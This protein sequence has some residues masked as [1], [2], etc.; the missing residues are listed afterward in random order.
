VR[1][2]PLAAI[3]SVALGIGRFA[4]LT[5]MLD[6]ALCQV[7]EVVQTEAG[8]VYLLDEERGE[9]SLVVHRGLSEL[10]SRDF[11]H[12]GLGEGLSGR[13]VVTGEPI[14][15]RNL[16]DDPRLT[17]MAARIEGFQAFASVP[18]RSNF[19]TYGTLNVHTRED[20]AFSEED[21]QLLTSMASQIGLAVANTRLYLDLRASERRF[22][23][24]VENA[25]DLIYLTDGRG[26]IV[27]ANAALQ[28]LLGRDP[29]A[30]DREPLTVLSLT[31]PDDREEMTRRLHDMLDG[32][33]LRAM[34]VRFLHAD[35][36]TGRWFSQTNVPLRDET[37]ALT[38]MQCLAHDITA[39]REMQSQVAQAERLADLGRMAAGIAHEIRNPLGAMVNSIEVLRRQGTTLDQ[40]LL[41]ILAAEVERL[42]TIVSE[43]LLFAR[44]PT[45]HAVPCDVGELVHTTAA[46]FRRGGGLGAGTTLEVICPDG[47][48]VVTADPNQLRQVLWNLLANASEAMGGGGRIDLAATLADD[49]RAVSVAVADQGPGVDRDAAVFEP[50]FTT[51]AQGTGLGLSIVARI[52]AEH[53]GRVEV[54]PRSGGG[55]VFTVTLPVSGEAAGAVA[56]GEPA[57]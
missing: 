20:R 2:N 45:R 26:R 16:K 27:Y 52:V 13:V 31:H 40:S 18:L 42:N 10:A 11:D 6:H 41:D 57:A 24:L 15:I 39:R 48:P 28:V 17:R 35:G 54:M 25:E 50:F 9:L 8:G 47:L 3:N 19:K 22:R 12:L 23:G 44:P 32:R 33:I 29:G 46:L 37:G 56:R 53:G 1:T 4:S 51:K 30:L 49:G 43:F 5:E 38:G 36:T 14:V 21:V 7:L 55:A 34:E